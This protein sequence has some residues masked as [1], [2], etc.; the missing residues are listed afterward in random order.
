MIRLEWDK[1]RFVFGQFKDFMITLNRGSDGNP[2][3]GPIR[4]GSK[5][6]SISIAEIA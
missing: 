4:R 3:T 6:M 1:D 2:E 5:M